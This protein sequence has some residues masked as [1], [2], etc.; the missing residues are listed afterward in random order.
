[1]QVPKRGVQIKENTVDGLEAV[2]VPPPFIDEDGW[3][4]KE[5]KAVRKGL[6]GMHALS[7]SD[8]V[9]YQWKRKGVRPANIHS[10]G[11]RLT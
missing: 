6:L 1:M 8:T 10:N 4:R 7:G 11:H 5:N 3:I 9:S 2:F